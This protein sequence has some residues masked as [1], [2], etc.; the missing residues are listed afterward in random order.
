MSN[1]SGIATQAS[2]I[3]WVPESDQTIADG[4][5]RAGSRHSRGAE[6]GR[7][8]PTQSLQC[9]AAMSESIFEKPTGGNDPSTNSPSTAAVSLRDAMTAALGRCV[10][11]H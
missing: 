4:L 3:Q 6:V 9:H 5:C 8:T 2:R 10:A 7:K 11:S 1:G